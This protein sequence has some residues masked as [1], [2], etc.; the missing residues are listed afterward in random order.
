MD[1]ESIMR[2]PNPHVLYER[3]QRLDDTSRP[4]SPPLDRRQMTL[5][6]VV[7]LQWF[8]QDV[9]CNNGILDREID[10]DSTDR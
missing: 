2:K 3:L 6:H 1:K 8:G 5:S 10:A 9:G 7:R 4:H